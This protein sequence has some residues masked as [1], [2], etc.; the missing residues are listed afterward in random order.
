LR[1]NLAEPSIERIVDALL[2]QDLFDLLS[3]IF[4]RQLLAG[5]GDLR[6]YFGVVVIL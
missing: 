5:S 2:G 4:K 1:A 6:R 3:G